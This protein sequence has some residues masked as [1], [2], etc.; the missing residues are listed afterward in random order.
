MR[1]IEAGRETLR[2][3]GKTV[4]EVAGIG[5]A[6]RAYRRTMLAQKDFYDKPTVFCNA[7]YNGIG[8]GL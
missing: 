7:L 1:S 4:K 2:Y 6:Q 5:P 8:Y 3:V